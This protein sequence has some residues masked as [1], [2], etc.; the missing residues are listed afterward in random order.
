MK[1]PIFSIQKLSFSNKDTQIISINKFD[2]YR[3][4]VYLFNGSMGSGKST[5]MKIFSKKVA[6][7]SN[8]LFYEDK[9]INKISA[10]TYYQDLFF[11]DQVNKRPWLGSSVE[12]YM[13]K[14]IKI[15]SSID[16]NKTFKRICNTMKI[17][18]YLLDKDISKLSEGEFR[19]IN[20][21]VAIA[22]DSKILVIDYLEK[23]LDLNRRVILNRVLKR[24][25]SHDG[26]TIIASSYNPE[27]FKMSTSVL[28][29]MDNGRI[30]QVRSSSHHSKPKTNRK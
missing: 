7:D 27:L 12:N 24:K 11:L 25:A 9:D 3:G 22:V 6:I 29:K 15:S 28:I 10:S 21:S 26:V 19:W 30:T 8:Q 14:K 18:K 16:S 23:F 2:L 17:P 5:L 13:L 4:A 20:L 1:K